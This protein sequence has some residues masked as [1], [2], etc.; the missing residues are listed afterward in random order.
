[1]RLTR[2]DL[3][4]TLKNTTL[5]LTFDGHHYTDL[6]APFDYYDEGSFGISASSPSVA[7]PPAACA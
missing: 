6:G 1:M 3:P 4:S 7:P 5:D 2:V